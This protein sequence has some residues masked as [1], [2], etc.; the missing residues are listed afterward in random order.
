MTRLSAIEAHGHI[1]LPW[2]HLCRCRRC[3]LC[4]WW[5]TLYGGPD[6]VNT[7][8]PARRVRRARGASRGESMK[9]S[10]VLLPWP[11]RGLMCVSPGPVAGCDRRHWSGHL[12]LSSP[13]SG[14]I[15]T[16]GSSQNDR[17]LDSGAILG[18]EQVDTRIDPLQRQEVHCPLQHRWVNTLDELPDQPLLGRD[19]QGTPGNHCLPIPCIFCR[20]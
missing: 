7:C 16:R 17:C 15:I 2:R 19:S 20:R 5:C 13:S 12:G 10:H 9:R 1:T 3:G 4:H 6:R 8:I 11:S 18:P 14:S